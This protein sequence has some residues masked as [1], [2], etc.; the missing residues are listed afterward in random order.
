VAVRFHCGRVGKTCSSPSQRMR[1]LDFAHIVPLAV[2][3]R[4]ERLAISLTPAG[5]ASK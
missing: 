5:F 4:R 3:I 2:A 1:R